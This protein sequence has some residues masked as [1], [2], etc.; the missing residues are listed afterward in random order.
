LIRVINLN[1]EKRKRRNN[2]LLRVLMNHRDDFL[3]FHKNKHQDQVRQARSVRQYV[4]VAESRREKDEA[5]SEAK[6]LQA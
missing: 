4:E 3:K 6:R 2:E 5:K 1:A